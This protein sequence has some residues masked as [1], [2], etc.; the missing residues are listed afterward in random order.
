MKGGRERQ[1][2]VKLHVLHI[3]EDIQGSLPR[4]SIISTSYLLILRLV[5]TLSSE[6]LN[7]AD[8]LRFEYFC[9]DGLWG[10]L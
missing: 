9:S 2:V 1:L 6:S 10:H 4:L 3:W 5:Q 7:F 8:V